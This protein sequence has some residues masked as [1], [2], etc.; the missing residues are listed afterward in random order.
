MTTAVK[1]IDSKTIDELVQRIVQAVNPLKVLL[2]GSAAR[3]RMGPDSDIDV[4]VVVPDGTHC[5]NTTQYLYKQLLGFSLPVDILVATS[6]MLERHKHN[7]GLVYRSI[8]A[9]GKEIY[10]A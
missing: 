7:T 6:A 9:E 5:L 3:E 10:A 1:Q 2:F 4:L 8:L